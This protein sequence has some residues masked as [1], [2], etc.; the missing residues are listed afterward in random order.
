M[1]KEVVLITGGTGLIGTVLQ[2]ILGEAGYEVI[3]LSRNVKS[4]KYLFIHS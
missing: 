2:T 3:L 4:K 1:E